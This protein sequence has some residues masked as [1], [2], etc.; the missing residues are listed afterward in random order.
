MYL[1]VDF[2]KSII[3]IFASKAIVPLQHLQSLASQFLRVLSGNPT[4]PSE[5][6]VEFG[7]NSRSAE[8]FPSLGNDSFVSFGELSVLNPH[9]QKLAGPGLLHE[10]ISPAHCDHEALDFMF[11]D[12]EARKSYTYEQ[13]DTLSTQFALRLLEYLPHGKT[14]R[15]VPVLLPQSPELYIALVGILKAGAAF[16]PLSLDAPIERIRFVVGDVRAS[17]IVTESSFSNVFT[18]EKCPPTVLADDHVTATPDELR[19]PLGIDPSG[20]AYIMY[21]S[22]STGAPKGVIISHSA[23]TQSLLAHEEHIP[24]FERFLQFAAPTFDV[25]VFEMFFPLLRGKTLVSCDRGR[26]LTDLPRV[27]NKLN[28][29]GAELTPTVAG[30]LLVERDKVPGLKVL[31]TIGEML[32]R[33]VVDQF[34][35]GVLQ[36]MYGPTEAAIHCTLA[37]GFEKNWKIGDIGVPLK[38]V[39]A[40]VL[41]TTTSDLEILPLG[42]TGELA[43]GG[44]QLADGY[45]NRPEL[46]KEVFIDSKEYGRLYRTGDRAR[47]L[48]S[49]RIECLGRV[50]AGQVKLR[51]QRIELGEIEEV[52]LGILGVRGAIA[53]VLGGRLV[54]YVGGG[55]E[56]EAVYDVCRKWL[57]RF[58]VPGDIVVLDELPRL[59]S[60]KADRKKLDKQYLETSQ[61]PAAEKGTEELNNMDQIVF[62]CVEELLGHKP[63]RQGSLIAMGLDS[64]QAIRLVS[65]LRS[66]DFTVEVVDV[67]RADCVEGIASAMRL[68]RAGWSNALAN[69]NVTAK[70]CAIQEAIRPKLPVQRDGIQD[71]IPCTSVQEAMLAETARDPEAYCNWI[72]LEL[73]LRLLASTIEE[74]FRG[75]IDRNE[76][77]RTGFMTAGDGFAQ[78]VWRSSRTKQ[79]SLADKVR[80]SWEVPS[81]EQLIEPPFAA[82]LVKSTDVWLLSIHLHHAVYDGWCWEQVLSDFSFHLSGSAKLPIR[83]QYRDIVQYELSRSRESNEFSEG[84]WKD[85]LDGAPNSRLPSFHG[86]SAT[87]SGVFTET[88]G[89]RSSRLEY[90]ASARKMGVSPQVLVQTAW[91]YLLSLF[92]GSPDVVFG[93][94]VSG[95]TVALP[96]V[97]DILGPT[98]LTLPLRVKIGQGTTTKDI[99]RDVHKSNRLVLENSGLPLREIRKVCEIEGTQFDSLLVWQQTLKTEGDPKLVRQVE[100]R[101][102]LEVSTPSVI[103]YERWC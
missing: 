77:L 75:V 51:G 78:V 36:G 28:I 53:S 89:L 32:T 33:Q 12:G 90:E 81:L 35:G 44:Y 70:F 29:D 47:I 8:T 57:P 22:G 3:S 88:I 6:F 20:P 10:L 24:L 68:S 85:F 101:D 42:W 64:I 102:R 7:V 71:I 43:V 55:V 45:L 61:T 60:G 23:A 48:S 14:R 65:A 2:S 46:T 16:V 91:G 41:S 1:V 98:I 17:V 31:L 72:L 9:P 5:Q 50:G 49:G 84:V 59:S 19:L 97:E 40:F 52:V 87:P 30:G 34:G 79:F 58:M 15:A 83:P 74:A 69:E 37:I 56:R 13:L 26:L 66:Q 4:S 103:S 21:T 73:P 92:M 80:S 99:V 18:W 76:I 93:T 95:R 54:V 82:S 25:F 94:V 27:I 100:N 86:H 11:A 96:G 63:S 38:T 62:D 39:S 67:L